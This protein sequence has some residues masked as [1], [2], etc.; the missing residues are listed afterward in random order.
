[1][2][3]YRLKCVGL[4]DGVIKKLLK[5]TKDY[6]EIFKIDKNQMR[7]V[8]KISEEDINKIF[9]S[10]EINLESELEKLAK[11]NAK[12][13]FIEDKDYPD[14]LRNISQPPI[15]LFYRG[16]VTKLKGLNIAVVGTRKCTSY[17]TM[18]CNKIITGLVKAGIGTVSGLAM[19]IDSV[20]HR[21]TLEEGGTT[22]GVIGC[23][24]DVIYPQ[25]NKDLY[26]KIPE[27]GGIILTEFPLGTQPQGYHFPLRNRIIVG[28]S[29]GVVIVESQK[30]G[31]SL[32][33]A[34]LALLEGRDTFAIPGEIYSECSEGCNNLIKNSQ[35]KLVMSAE[36]ILE[37]YGIVVES[38]TDN[39]KSILNLSGI[40]KEIYDI[41]VGVKNLD[42]ILLSTFL[43][44]G[45]VLAILMDL[46]L[47]NLVTSVAG[48]NYRR[49]L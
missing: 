44:A 9:S 35:A 49:K 15:F 12:I 41:L 4:T 23:G 30:S 10:K 45:E 47:K 36:D 8:L 39:K 5:I 26:E 2:D 16:D 43:K 33:T 28:L 37:E 46:E 34:E 38:S 20:C 18:A 31:G 14:N 3:W 1:M 32:I 42:E 6:D 19:G 40:E 7:H 22:I 21:K 25:N 11:K 27:S 24:L 13:L 17:G 48:G 29:R